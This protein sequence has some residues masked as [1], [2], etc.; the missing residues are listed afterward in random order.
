M[1]QVYD[2]LRKLTSA[3]TERS[4]NA[5]YQMF[6]N[7]KAIMKEDACMK[8]YDETKPQYI[9]T[10]ASEVGLGAVLPQKRSNTIYHRDEVPDN[11]ILRP[12]A[13]SRRSLIGAEKRYSNIEEKHWAWY[14]VLKNSI[15]IALQER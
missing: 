6:D 4:W 2:L 14:M 1:V 11:N 5:T 13:F 7:A 8:F 12:M 15:T 9:E 3:K 10:D